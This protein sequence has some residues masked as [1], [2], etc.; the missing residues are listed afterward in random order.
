[1][2][3]TLQGTVGREKMHKNMCIISEG[4]KVGPSDIPEGLVK[5]STE[6][7]LRVRQKQ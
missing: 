4:A 7:M 5:S 6:K 2:V 1:M 3:C